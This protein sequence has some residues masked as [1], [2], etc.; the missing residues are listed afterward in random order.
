M[1]SGYT[2]YLI[3]VCIWIAVTPLVLWSGCK[4][5]WDP[6]ERVG[7]QGPGP[8]IK[9]R[10]GWSV[11]E[12]PALVVFPAIYFAIKETFDPIS[13]FI[14]LIWVVH[15]VHRSLIWPWFGERSGDTMP[16]TT[17]VSAI[18]FNVING[19]FI[20]YLVVYQI[21]FVQLTLWSFLFLGG[22][23]LFVIGELLNIGSDYRLLRLRN[24]QD[25]R[26]IVPLGFPFSLVACPNLFGEV[27]IWI[28]FALMTVGLATLAFALW[29]LANLV[30]RAL[31][32]RDQ[33]RDLS[34]EYPQSRKAIIPGVV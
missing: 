27:L 7:G 31:W 24:Q 26:Y 10:L 8:R 19:S 17:V 29:T 16:L 20:G 2:I 15:Y 34:D 22:A 14:V 4:R 12:L 18:A 13:L 11:Q 21:D 32:R 25:E 33:Y 23:V 5:L 3:S 28:G 9:S 1:T 6:F 30:P